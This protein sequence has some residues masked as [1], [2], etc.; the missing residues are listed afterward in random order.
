MYQARVRCFFTFSINASC[1]SFDYI[2]VLERADDN[3]EYTPKQA[4]TFQNSLQ[5]PPFTIRN[6]KG[7]IV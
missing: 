6:F 7:K 5:T 3:T 1:K 2:S 4:K